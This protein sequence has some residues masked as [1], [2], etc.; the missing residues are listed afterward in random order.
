MKAHYSQYLS[1]KDWLI[2]EKQWNK[3]WQQTRESQFTLGNGYICSRGVLEELPYDSYPGT[4]IAGLYD[5]V[6]AQ[7]AELVNLPN[8]INFKIVTEGEKLDII[9]SD[10][11]NHYRALDMKKGLL[12]R[13]TMFSNNRK[14]RFDYQS[15]RFVSMDNKNIAAMRIWL[16]PLDA[17]ANLS[18]MRSIDTGT[19]NRGVLTE[20]RKK[21][22]EI[23]EIQATKNTSYVNVETFGRGVQVG[24]A[25]TIL[26]SCG[27]KIQRL[28]DKSFNLKLRRGQT[29]TF[30]LIFSLCSHQHSVK[31]FT[32]NSH[33]AAVKAGFNKLVAQNAQ[34]WR[35]KWDIA[36]VDIVGDPVME[37]S[38]RFN[39]YHLLICEPEKNSHV[40][41]GARSLSGEGYRGHIFWDAD[42]FILP[43]YLYTSPSA[44][45]SMLLYRY[46]RLGAAREI[47]RQRGYKGAMFPWESAHTGYD[48]T[49]TWFKN[50]DGSIIKIMTMER[51]DHITADIAYA[52][53]HYYRV[54]GDEN[55]LL[56]Y[57]LEIFLECARFWASRVEYSK[58]KKKYEIKHVIGPNEFQEDVN[59][60]AYTNY[61]A[62]W[63]MKYGVL[64]YKMLK[65]KKPRQV[66]ILADRINLK[67][68]ELKDW[69]QK[70]ELLTNTSFPKGKIIEEFN[71]YFKKRFVNITELDHNLMPLIPKGFKLSDIGKTQFVKQADV[72]MMLYL[73]GDQF[74]SR[75][76]NL[77]FH[78]YNKRTLH[79]SSL[80]PSI[81]AIVGLESGEQDR[82]L[83][84]YVNSANTDLLNIHGNTHEGIHSASAGGTWQALINGFAGVRIKRNVL[85]IDPHMPP[86]WRRMSFKIVWQGNPLAVTVSH[87]NIKLRYRSARQQTIKLRVFG[88]QVILEANKTQSFSIKDKVKKRR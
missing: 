66:E 19:T 2:E 46:D 87:K 78:Y 74:D 77:N 63:N 73:F 75:T 7:V 10:V 32:L 38:S 6:A 57:G 40:S 9:S 11:L 42:I 53:F 16:K 82:A 64:L 30:T 56:R 29:A 76:K 14:H 62:K 52:V 23:T 26:V 41:V 33:R 37:K 54:T 80:S 67:A 60:N 18:I 48:V 86:R 69:Q 81:Y 84:Y 12:V 24:Y 21:H 49:P 58:R 71:G 4:Y 3:G 45:K 61:I 51:E 17:S 70:A 34:A 22:Y 83:H 39:I 55:F 36:G 35:K 27:G 28:S 13:R 20:G 43:F 72:V 50:L 5:R 65:K 47:A 15:M 85:S 79:K 25:S 44:A 1:T 59:N 68:A 8:P 31:N 88:R